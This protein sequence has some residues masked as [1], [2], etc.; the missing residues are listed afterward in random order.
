MASGTTSGTGALEAVGPARSFN[1]FL[2]FGTGS[3][4]LE[5]LEADGS[6]WLKHPDATAI[7][8]DYYKVFEVPAPVRLRWNVTAHS[9]AI[10]WGILPGLDG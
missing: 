7:T 5:V 9:G 10:K 3:V 8:T 2:D 1:L 4:D 6:T